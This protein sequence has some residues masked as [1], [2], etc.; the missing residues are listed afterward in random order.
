MRKCTRCFIEKN[1][2]E[3]NKC[4]DRYKDKIYYYYQSYC[5]QC[6]RERKVKERLRNVEH[7]RK[8]YKIRHERNKERRHAIYKASYLKSSLGLTDTY[9]KRLISRRSSLKPDDIPKE[10]IEAKR[11]QVQLKR[12]IKERACQI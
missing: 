12:I 7:Q 10:M 1:I 3:F 9:V 2:S 5:K 8:M 4:K 11:L 6:N